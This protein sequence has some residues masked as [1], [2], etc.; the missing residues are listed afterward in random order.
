MI[1]ESGLPDVHK[2][3]KEIRMEGRLK[4]LANIVID[5]I[6]DPETMDSLNGSESRIK[7][8]ENASRM[9]DC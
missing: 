6:L 9:A 2:L 8:L 3:F 5:R 1:K 7:V 4:T